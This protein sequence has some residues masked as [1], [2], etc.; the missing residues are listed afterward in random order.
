MYPAPLTT[1][2]GYYAQPL[3]N[4]PPPRARRMTATT[5]TGATVAAALL[6]LAVRIFRMC[7]EAAP[8]K[9]HLATVC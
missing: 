9:H 7:C 4:T 3:A 6:G 5:R 2:A 8:V 1:A